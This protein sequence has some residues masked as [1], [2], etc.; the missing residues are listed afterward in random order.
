MNRGSIKGTNKDEACAH[1]IAQ[2]LHGSDLQR[3]L[4]GPSA[5][6]TL[7][8]IRIKDTVGLL[9]Q[10]LPPLSCCTDEERKN[11]RH[12]QGLLVDLE[13]LSYGL[14]P[15]NSL[16]EDSLSVILSVSV[17]NALENSLEGGK[18]IWSQ[19]FHATLPP[20]FSDCAE[21]ELP[22]L[23]VRCSD[24]SCLLVGKKQRQHQAGTGDLVECQENTPK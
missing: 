22:G 3:C 11:Q 15:L 20:L 14:P 19:R 9:S 7:H 16:A 1:P 18:F 13:V 8:C 2:H 6:H 21:V 17:T 23:N 12:R 4:P 24:A 5:V 10:Y